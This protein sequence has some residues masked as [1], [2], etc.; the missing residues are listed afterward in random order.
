MQG[1]QYSVKNRADGFGGVAILVH[2][3]FYVREIQLNHI[4]PGVELCAASISYLRVNLQVFSIY[5]P[6]SIKLSHTAWQSVFSQI[7]SNSNICGD[8]NAHHSAWGSYTNKD[9]KALLEAIDSSGLVFLNNGQ[10]TKLSPP[11]QMQ[12]AVDLTLATTNLVNKCRWNIMDDMQSAVDLTLA[13]TN[14]VNKCRWNIMDD[15]FG[16]DH[17]IIVT[18]L[19]ILKQRFRSAFDRF[20]LASGRTGMLIVFYTKKKVKES[21]KIYCNSLNKNTPLSTIWRKAKNIGTSTKQSPNPLHQELVEEILCNLSPEGPYEHMKQS[22]PPLTDSFNNM[23]E[24]FTFQELDRAIKCSH[25]SSPGLDNIT[26]PMVSNLPAIAKDKL[27]EIYNEWWVESK[28]LDSL[29]DIVILPIL[30]PGKPANSV[31]SYRPISLMSCITKTFERI[32]KWRMEW[33]FKTKEIL[34]NCQYGFKK[35]YG[36]TDALAELVSHIQTSFSANTY[37]PDLRKVTGLQMPSPNWSLTFRPPLAQI[38]IY[39]PCLPI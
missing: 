35:G 29:R 36:T 7:P 39:R 32:I 21:W 34:P 24:P 14:L 20:Q 28:Y 33:W 37:L 25:N 12:S 31:K 3:A 22:H 2:E 27:L 19:D 30:K 26:Y 23:E 15:T 5:K 13:T 38:P 16:S 4:H 17:F 11:S 18:E 1:Y 6:P 9:G 8:F 10:P